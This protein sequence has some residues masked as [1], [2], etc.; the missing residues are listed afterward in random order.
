MLRAM[1]LGTM[2]VMAACAT[3]GGDGGGGDDEP[4]DTCGDDV[5]DAGKKTSCAADCP[6]VPVCGNAMCEAGENATSCA[7]DCPVCGDNVCAATEDAT[8]CVQDC[9]AKLEV[10]NQS[11]YN[12]Y[13]LY[14][15]PCGQGWYPNQ[16]T[17][18]L[19]PGA[20]FTLGAI[21]PGCWMFRAEGAGTIYWQT[22]TGVNLAK[23]QR[24]PW[25]LGN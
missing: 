25:T 7:S 18:T 1:M 17:N 13:R 14:A 19:A 15:A 8:A 16:L 6:S 5:C 4:E 9:G 12:V 2:L 10:R 24:Y 3:D 20:Q 21:P 23:G 11:S 22:P